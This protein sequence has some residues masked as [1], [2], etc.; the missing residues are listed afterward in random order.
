VR[1]PFLRR[2]PLWRYEARRA[3]WAAGLAPPA[4]L[5]VA[6][7]MAVVATLNGSPEPQVGRVLLAGLEALLP[8]AL[9]MT[10]VTLVARDGCRELQLSLPTRYARTLG[11]RLGVLAASGAVLALLFTAGLGLAGRWTGPNP[12]ASPLVWAPPALWLSALAVL[13]G[14]VGRSV[15]VATTVVAVVWLGEQLFASRLVASDWTRPF[16][17]FTTSRA[18]VGEAWLTNRLA[19][20]G[21]GLLF[22]AVV[23]ALLRRPQLLLSEEEV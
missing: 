22:V 21:S 13:L 1:S 20:T 12:L 23:V 10:A 5:A 14:L 8:L 16:F 18:G 9:G 4:A 7:A 19:L 3:G 2:V 17:L 15:V 6:T 11:R